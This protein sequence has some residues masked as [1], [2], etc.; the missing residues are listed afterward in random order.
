MQL[1]GNSRMINHSRH[2]WCKAFGESDCWFQQTYRRVHTRIHTIAVW[3]DLALVILAFPLSFCL[4]F[5]G[6]VGWSRS[7]L[8]WGNTG[9]DKEKMLC[10]KRS[11][12][13]KQALQFTCYKVHDMIGCM[14]WTR[15][16]FTFFIAMMKSS[17]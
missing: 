7:F 9:T 12:W 16:N 4:I 1:H 8:L 13:G 14:T 17:W 10:S 2:K 5:S 3:L 15:V 11:T 6:S